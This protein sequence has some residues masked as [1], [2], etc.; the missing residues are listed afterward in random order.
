VR[1]GFVILLGAC[2]RLGFGASG[3]TDAAPGPSYQEAVLADQPLA[4][5]RFEETAGAVAVD[6]SGHGNDCTYRVNG[7]TIDYA[8]AG[9]LPDPS[10]HAIG[11][12]GLGNPGGGTEAYARFPSTVYPWSGDFTI[13]LWIAPGM[14][15]PMNWDNSLVVSEVYPTSGFRTG[16]T[17][18]LL[19]ELWT[20]ESGGTADL[21]AATPMLAGA[22]NHLA[23]T[24]HGASVT[25]YLDGASIATGD[26]DY[27]VPPPVAD[28]GIGSLEGMPSSG[29]FD[30]VA[31][32][33]VAL[34]PAQIAAH[35]AASRS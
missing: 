5:Y 16:W 29:R 20:T 25:I 35:V 19:P 33:G 3:T 2:G 28:G 6:S 31:I 12:A 4:Y 11:F 26:I 14:S 15:P 10:N 7:G 22:W 9:A 17:V 32:Y 34:S 1:F 18:D 23:F 8:V 27:V 21:L 30:E 24:K 13:E